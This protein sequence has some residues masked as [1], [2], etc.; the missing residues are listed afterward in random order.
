MKALILALWAFTGTA[1]AANIQRGNWEVGGGLSFS[2]YSS[3]E[4]FSLYPEAQYFVLNYFS[5]G[6]ELAYSTGSNI[7]TYYSI[8]PVAS[9]YFPVSETTVPFVSLAP[10]TW[11]RYSSSKYTYWHATTKFGVKFFLTESV[12]FGPV[13]QWAHYY[14]DSR[15]NSGNSLSV[16]GVF[17]IHL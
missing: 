9:L 14:A 16:L 13:V 4:S 1:Q 15:S 3:R 17:A 5:V 2:T 7:S 8:G 6:G 10:A 12:A 11:N